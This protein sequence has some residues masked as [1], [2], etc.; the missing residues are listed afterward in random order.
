[1]SNNKHNSSLVFKKHT[2]ALWMRMSGLGNLFLK[3]ADN[4]SLMIFSQDWTFWSPRMTAVESTNSS[5]RTAR[6]YN[7]DSSRKVLRSSP[8]GVPS[9]QNRIMVF[10]A[11]TLAHPLTQASAAHRYRQTLRQFLTT[12]L[13]STKV[14]HQ[15]QYLTVR[16]PNSH[17]CDRR[18]DLHRCIMKPSTTTIS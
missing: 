4:L 17:K 7:K 9:A 13:P 18:S 16:F 11:S 15:H 3:L 12:N 2:V 6:N 5:K 10:L 14:L 8:G 1:M